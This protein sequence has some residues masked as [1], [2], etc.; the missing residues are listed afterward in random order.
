MQKL[1]FLLLVLCGTLSLHAQTANKGPIGVRQAN[2]TRVPYRGAPVMIAR[3]LVASTN[4]ATNTNQSQNPYVVFR[5]KYHLNTVRVNFIDAWYRARQ[6]SQNKNSWAAGN[7]RATGYNKVKA[8]VNAAR[9]A[10]LQVIINWHNTGENAYSNAQ[11][12]AFVQGLGAFHEWRMDFWRNMADAYAGD[13]GVIFELSNEPLFNYSQ[14]SNPTFRNNLKA[15]YNAVASRIYANSNPRRRDNHRIILFSFHQ[16][17]NDMTA[18]VNATTGGNTGFNVDWFLAA[19]GFHAYTPNNALAGITNLANNYPVICTELDYPNR[20][21]PGRPGI[22][23]GYET[24]LEPTNNVLEKSAIRTLETSPGI[25][26]G[27][28]WMEWRDWG[29]LNFEFPELINA[30]GGYVP[31]NVSDRA[32]LE[33]AKNDAIRHNY[34]WWTGGGGGQLIANGVYFLKKASSNHYIYAVGNTTELKSRTNTNGNNSKWRF[35]HLGNNEYTIRNIGFNQRM[36]IPFG[37]VGQGQKVARTSWEG[38]INH[39]KWKAIALGNGEFQFLPKHDQARAL[40]I[41][42]GNANVVHLW[43]KNANNGNQRFRLVGTSA[44]RAAIDAPADVREQGEIFAPVAYPNPTD[45]ELTLN[46]LQ[47]KAASLAV[48]SLSGQRLMHREVRPAGGRAVINLTDLATGT[49]VVSVLQGGERHA[50][51]VIR[52]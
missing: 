19:V 28:G 24:R 26:R 30:N 27:I 40:D 39:A 18:T 51:R 49:Y 35:T 13:P 11:E 22:T 46:G 2:G 15:V 47:D 36:E 3:E 16:T 34:R 52:R 29:E 10:G 32:S 8:A 14:Y 1:F 33:R 41:W 6:N 20:R 38:N 4:L 12:D 45:G 44:S 5:D 7:L 25:P 50:L 48:F 37:R 23:G 17:R 9:A 42:A 31:S 21:R 43:G